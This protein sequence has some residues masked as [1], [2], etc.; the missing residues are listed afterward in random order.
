MELALYCPVYGY[1]EKEGDTPGRQGDYFTSVSV[2]PLFGELLALRFARWLEE[3]PGQNVGG[4][5]EFQIVEAAAHDGRLAKDILR[6]LQVHRGDTFQKIVYWIVEPSERRRQWQRHSLAEFA[7]KVRWVHRL[8]E[9]SSGGKRAVESRTGAKG[10]S[11]VRGV[12]FSNE[13]LDAMPAHRF[14]WDAAKAK[15]FEWGVDWDAAGF[16]WTPLPG[17]PE[18]AVQV[19]GWPEAILRHLPDGFTTETCPAANQ[20][21]AEAA[22]ILEA[23]K[24][25]TFDYGLTDEEYLA[26]ERREGT[27]R[28]YRRHQ[29]AA[30]VLADPGDQDL[31][32]HVNFSALSQVGEGAG[33]RTELLCSQEEFLMGI[34]TP[35]FRGEELFGEWTQERTAQFQTLTHPGHLGRVFRVLVQ[36]R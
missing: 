15:W 25:I 2:G 22:A 29:V 4:P 1:Y 5:L 8:S 27:V 31:T 32:A 23:G 9:L 11:G 3:M 7:G 26:P 13:L 21:W 10:S 24:L 6:W 36:S 16:R 30:N 35:V 33:L 19:P 34:A 28:A 18:K 17:A 12:I 14:S 20:W